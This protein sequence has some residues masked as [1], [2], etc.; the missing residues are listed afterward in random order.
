[1]AKSK[2]AHVT[3]D[4]D[5]VRRAGGVEAAIHAWCEQSDD[6]S[7]GVVGSAFSTSGPGPGWSK[8]HTAGDFAARAMSEGALHYI[9]ASNGTMASAE[10]VDDDEQDEDGEY[11][12]GTFGDGCGTMVRVGD[13]TDESVVRLECPSE[14]D[15]I[16]YPAVAAEMARAVIDHHGA[17]SDKAE[18]LA[19]IQRIRAA[20]EA[21]EDIDLDDLA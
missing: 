18:W 17:E 4:I 6:T 1:M 3:L 10:V 8:N 12:D 16:A 9:D 20:A 5:D 11:P 14:D 7:S 15:A 2:T 19:L 13:W 21:F